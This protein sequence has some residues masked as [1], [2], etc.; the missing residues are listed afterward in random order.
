MIDSLIVGFGIAGLNY[1]EQL[2]Q[3]KKKFIVLAPKEDSASHIAAGIINPTVLKRFN[4]VW[5]SDEFLNYALPHYNELQDLIQTKIIHSI[6]ILRILNNNREQNEWKVS[7][8]K[9]ILKNYLN[10]T[11]ISG[12]KYHGIKAPLNYGEVKKS[13]KVDNKIL[14]YKYV[15]NIIPNQF[16]DCKVDHT[17]L[18]FNS[19]GIKY[20]G[21]QAKKV[22]FCEGFQNIVNPFFNYLP[23]I[24][25]KGEML[26][27][28]CDHLINEVIFKGPIFL[29]PIGEKKFWV[30]ATFNREDKTTSITKK[31]KEW[32]RSKLEKFLNL[33]YQ[34]IEHKAQ[35]RATV[36]DRKPLLGIHPLNNK[37]FILNGM[38]TRGVLMAPLLSQWLYEYIENQSKLPEAA[39]VKRFENNYFR[40]Q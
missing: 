16:I 11:L 37:L 8:S 31:G 38:G 9:P 24:G 39:D 36:I 2:R 12:E 26:I 30:G 20:K 17:K 35:I 40:N 15:K 18:K 23:L 29:S 7:C 3:H 34:I 27:I 1:A 22:V 6:P 28:K 33:P 19:Q 10:N 21:I 4:S 14:I 25:S 5:K 32:L 13:A